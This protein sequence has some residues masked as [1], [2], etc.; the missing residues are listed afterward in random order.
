[1]SS[2]VSARSRLARWRAAA[3]RMGPTWIAAVI[4]A[5]PATMASLV[6]AGA[7]FEHAL[8]WVV[9]VA[10]LLGLATLGIAI[11]ALRDAIERRSGPN[12]ALR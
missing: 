9:A 1:M 5:G 6:V 7:G 3:G 8:L 12:S 10:A 4:A 11:R 2:E